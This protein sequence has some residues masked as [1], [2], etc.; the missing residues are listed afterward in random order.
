[1]LVNS[2]IFDF[3]FKPENIAFLVAGVAVVAIL[4]FE[5][6]SAI[7]GGTVHFISAE[8]NISL[9]SHSGDINSPF[10]WLNPGGV[11]TIVLLTLFLGLFSLTGF[12]W[13]WI[14]EGAGFEPLFWGFTAPVVA[15][16]IMPVMRVSSTFISKHLP[17]E[18]SNAVDIES[19]LGSYGE[20]TMGPITT[21]SPGQAKFKDEHGISHYLTA[22]SEVGDAQTGDTVVLMGRLSEPNYGYVIRKF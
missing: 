7:V 15:A 21:D 4:V 6:M 18:T 3:F 20:V 17:Q 22:Y 2:A 11:P 1:M 19:L 9:D 16:V 5:L 12:G 8:T 13:Q 10:D 14:W